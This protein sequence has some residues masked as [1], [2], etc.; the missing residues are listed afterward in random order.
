MSITAATESHFPQD[1]SPV[2]STR[3][4]AKFLQQ[5]TKRDCQI[6]DLTVFVSLLSEL[7]GWNRNPSREDLLDA[8]TNPACARPVLATQSHAVDQDMVPLAVGQAQRGGGG[9]VHTLRQSRARLA[10]HKRL[11]EFCPPR[12]QRPQLQHPPPMTERIGG[13]VRRAVG[14]PVDAERNGLADLGNVDGGG[15]RCTA[16]PD[17][18]TRTALKSSP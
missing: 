4:F 12:V 14:G 5:A 13:D 16:S 6:L 11:F 17:R 8:A 10:R 1:R 18:Q 2:F 3:T 7:P 9:M 15:P